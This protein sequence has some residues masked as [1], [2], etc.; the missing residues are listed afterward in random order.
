MFLSLEFR[1]NSRCERGSLSGG[2]YIYLDK[3]P[4][5]TWD[6]DRLT[7]TETAT[8][9]V[10]TIYTPGSFTPLI[11]VETQTAELAKAVR[12]TLAEKFQQEA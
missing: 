5:V 12:R 7:I 10:Q 8:Q 4:E 9:R 1:V 6:G 2:E 11:R 3:T